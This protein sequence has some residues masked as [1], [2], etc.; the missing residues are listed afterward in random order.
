MVIFRLLIRTAT[1][2]LR[3]S[4]TGGGV[5]NCSF[6]CNIVGVLTTFFGTISLVEVLPVLVG[7]AK[8][9]F[10][11]TLFWAAIMKKHINSLIVSSE[12]NSLIVSSELGQDG[13]I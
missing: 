13:G 9:S 1:D 8:L 7:L 3:L 10:S 2:V 12:I 6:G 5:S 4:V 11:F